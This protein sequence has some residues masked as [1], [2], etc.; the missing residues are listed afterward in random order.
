[1]DSLARAAAECAPTLIL[2]Y[3]NRGLLQQVGE[4]PYQILKTHFRTVR[5]VKS[6]AHTH[7]SFGAQRH[8]PK[9]NAVE[10]I[11]VATA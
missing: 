10:H 9:I 3:P 4:D 7:S 2:S 1:M 11:Y 5:R 8:A 6:L